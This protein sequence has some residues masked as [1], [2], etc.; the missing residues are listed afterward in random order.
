MTTFINRSS[1]DTLAAADAANG[2]LANS[3]PSVF[4]HGYN[5]SV[6]SY[7]LCAVPAAASTAI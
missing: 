2:V 1:N 4:G 7:E 3:I 5:G 6:G